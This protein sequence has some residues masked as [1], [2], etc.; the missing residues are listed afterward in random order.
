MFTTFEDKIIFA[1]IWDEIEYQWEIYNV[2]NID[3]DLWTIT[4][5]NCQTGISSIHHKDDML[6]H[7]EDYMIDAE[8]EREAL[9][10]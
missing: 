9:A 6:D 5:Q 2:V 7:S 3:D 8:I 1:S 4:L 10:E